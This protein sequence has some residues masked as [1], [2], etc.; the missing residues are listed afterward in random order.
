MLAAS[1]ENHAAVVVERADAGVVIS[2]DSTSDIVNA[3]RSLM[4]NSELRAQYATNARAY[5]ERSFNI[6]RIADRFIEVFSKS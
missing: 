5:A 2:P 4:E 1:R 3:A 6:G